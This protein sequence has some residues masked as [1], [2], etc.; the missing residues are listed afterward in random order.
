MSQAYELLVTEV[1]RVVNSPYPTQLKVGLHCFTT[2]AILCSDQMKLTI[3]ATT[4]NYMSKMLGCRRAGMGRSAKLPGRRAR[5]ESLTSATTMAVRAGDHHKALH[6]RE[7][8]RCLA[9]T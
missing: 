5:E 2:L 1:D 7:R 6:L 8:P 3:T 9:S 4:H